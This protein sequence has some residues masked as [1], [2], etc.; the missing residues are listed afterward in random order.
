MKTFQWTVRVM[1]MIP[2][3]T[4]LLEVFMGLGSLKTIGAELPSELTTQA[5]VDNNWRFLGTVWAGYAALIL[6][7]VNDPLRHATLLR[8]LLTIL[9][10]S[11]IARAASVLLMGWPVPAFI[12]AMAFELFVMPLM[13]LWQL[14]VE[15]K[16]RTMS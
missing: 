8:I 13:M 7:A 3:V 6:Y 10:L 12:A 5:S 1:A 11:G 4:G 15:R 9:F 16:A 2:L 14:R